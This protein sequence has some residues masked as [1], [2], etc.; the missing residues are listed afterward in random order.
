[1]SSLNNHLHNHNKQRE[2]LTRIQDLNFIVTLQYYTTVVVG[3][4]RF[5]CR[6]QMLIRCRLARRIALT[7]W[8]TLPCSIWLAGAALLTAA[9]KDLTNLAEMRKR[10][11]RM[12]KN[13]SNGLSCKNLR[14][15]FIF[16][17]AYS[18]FLP[19]FSVRFSL[20]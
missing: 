12:R 6:V 18:L 9:L 10:R 2:Q 13:S 8:L 5:A 11:M 16:L 20:L 3:G 17:S 1:M 15:I 14:H 4:E 7:S 19:L